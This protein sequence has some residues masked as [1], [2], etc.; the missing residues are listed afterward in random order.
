M[1]KN[2]MT[3]YANDFSEYATDF[4]PSEMIVTA[5]ARQLENKKVIFAGTGLPMVGITLAQLTH[6]PD[7]I[8]VFE[9]GA[10]GP[11]LNRS[12]PLSVGDS[13]TT[14]SANFIQ[15]LNSSFELTQRGFIDVGFI[16]GAE[17]DP[18]G[19]LNS[20]M[21]GNFPENYM[22]PDIRLPG[23]GGAGDMSC[24]C[25]YTI[26]IVQHELRRFVEK[27]QYTTSPG[28]LDGSPDARKKAGLQGK[29]PRRVITT[30]A[31]MGF[32]DETKRMKILATMPGET[33]ESVQAATG[34]ELLVDENLYEFEPPT[35]E[36]IRLIR[37]KID[38]TQIYCKR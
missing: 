19:N 1:R 25:T 5:G 30:K 3:D 33:V 2:D 38:P 9:G 27:L 15:G 29:G 23:S 6:G 11:T 13:R 26:L 24:S 21:I 28:H 22:N 37:E 8:P 35:K 34:F 4:S 16:G 31:L 18:Y 12:L 17:V 10:V 36:E 14:G 20:T 7:I 32:D